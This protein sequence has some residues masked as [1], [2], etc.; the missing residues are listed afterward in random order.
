MLILSGFNH[1][2]FVTVTLIRSSWKISVSWTFWVSILLLRD[3]AARTRALSH[4]A[5]YDYE[6]VRKPTRERN[7]KA[8]CLYNDVRGR[9]RTDPTSDAF[10]G[11]DWT[12]V[13][14]PTASVAQCLSARSSTAVLVRRMLHWSCENVRT[15]CFF[16]WM[17]ESTVKAAGVSRNLW[18]VALC[19]QIVTQNLVQTLTIQNI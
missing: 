11:N 17:C 2:Q 5:D 13:Y 8:R 12:R 4:L 9:F 18:V 14:M 7:N 1:S 3:W 19:G 6:I 10:R 16:F 15:T